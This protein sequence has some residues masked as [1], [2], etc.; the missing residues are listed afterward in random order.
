[1]QATGQHLL[2]NIQNVGVNFTNILWQLFS[3]LFVANRVWQ[4]AQNYGN[5]CK[6]YHLKFPPKNLVQLLGKYKLNEREL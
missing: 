2:Y 6:I 5:S 1:V 3:M 4:K